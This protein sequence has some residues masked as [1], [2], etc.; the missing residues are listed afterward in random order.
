MAL[1]RDTLREQLRR[2]EIQP[3]Y[4]FFGPETYLRNAAVKTIADMCFAEGDFRDLND[5]IFSLSNADDLPKVL[6]VAQQ[7]PMMS[8]R[9]VVR[10]SELR[11]SA[12]GYRDTVTEDH[13]AMLA[14]YFADPSPTTTL[15]L[16]AEELNGVRKIGKLLKA[17][18]GAIEFAAL[19]EAELYDW[20][21]KEFQ[22]NG[23]EI[24]VATLREL[25]SRIGPDLH[26]MTNEVKKLATA[27]LPGGRVTVDLVDALIAN[28]RE[29]D[30]FALTDAIVAGRYGP[31][32]RLLEKALDDGAEPL[33]LL[34]LLGYNYRRLL[35]VKDL[36]ERGVDRREVANVVKLR[37]NDQEPFL[38]AARRVELKKLQHAIKKLAQTDVAIKTSLGG[39]GPAGARMQIEML[40]CELALL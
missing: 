12:S 6:P 25:V 11:V 7:L 37:Y 39:S 27:A 26:R 20:T 21:R 29:V 36:M 18:P 3:V 17:Q 24:D 22:K 40:V 31:A 38:A 10:I 14:A 1:T 33:Q 8:Q 23:A 4:I 34:G 13:E 5:N 16:I 30:H 19:S 32:I 15:I 35:M 9:R 28:V 2:K